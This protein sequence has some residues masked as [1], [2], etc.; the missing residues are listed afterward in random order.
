MG[1]DPED[2]EEFFDSEEEEEEEE[3]LNDDELFE[4]LAEKAELAKETA[5][6]KRLY[7]LD[8][9]ELLKKESYRKFTAW[10]AHLSL[11]EF[12]AAY[13]IAT[14]V[15]GDEDDEVDIDEDLG[16]L[17]F[18]YAYGFH[19]DSDHSKRPHYE[20]V[21]CRIPESDTD[22]AVPKDYVDYPIYHFEW[23]DFVEEV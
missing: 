16:V 5:F 1:V 19:P 22:I 11:G 13:H 10:L 17:W 9:E 12:V 7:V 21:E 23:S 3:F 14:D 8:F 18:K 15:E 6:L 4:E 2:P 20:M